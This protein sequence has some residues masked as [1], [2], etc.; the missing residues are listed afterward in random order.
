MTKTAKRITRGLL[1]AL[2][3]VAVVVPGLSGGLIA[4][5]EGASAE[6]GVS[7]PTAAPTF[8]VIDGLDKSKNDDYLKIGDGSME[9]DSKICVD[10]TKTP[11]YTFQASEVGT[12]VT[13]Y[14]LYT[15]DDTSPDLMGRNPKAWKLQGSIDGVN[16]TDIHTVTDDDKLPTVANKA[17]YTYTFENAIPYW[18]Y[19][20]TFTERQGTAGEDY[21]LMQLS[22]IG[23][24]ATA[25]VTEVDSYDA[26]VAAV[27]KGGNIKL[28][29]D[30]TLT[31]ELS[32]YQN[33]VSLDLNGYVISGQ[34]ICV[35]SAAATFSSV[36]M[37]NDSRPTAAHNDEG[38]PAGGVV[39]SEIHMTRRTDD[40]NYANCKAYFYANGGTATGKLYLDTGNALVDHTGDGM[41]VFMGGAY[42]AGTTIN[43][44]FYY[45]DVVSTN[46]ENPF[47]TTNKKVVFKNGDTVY[48]T[49]FAKSGDKVGIM[50]DAPTTAPEAGLM[51]AGW[52][53]YGGFMNNTEKVI[54]ADTTYRAIWMKGVASVA[55]LKA[56]IAAGYGVKLTADIT[57]SED[58]VLADG[59][60]VLVFDLNGHVIGT[61]DRNKYKLRAT[62][63]SKE[64][65]T[66][67][68]IID[69][70]PTA[71]HEGEGLPVGGF[72]N[73]DINM[74]ALWNSKEVKIYANGGTIASAYAGSGGGQIYSTSSTPSVFLGM[75]TSGGITV[76]GGTY[77][78]TTSTQTAIGKL[79][80]EGAIITYMNGETLYAK[81]ETNAKKIEPPA[82]APTKE[83]YRFVGWYIVTDAESGEKDAYDFS[84]PLS[85]GARITLYAEWVDSASPVI[86]GV[87]ADSVY[88]TTQEVTVT[89]DS[90]V[91]VT[92]DGTKVTL[93]GGTFS[94]DM[95]S[96]ANR[97]IVATD[98][99][100]N[101]TTLVVT[102]GH[103]F[104]D[105]TEKVDEDCSTD[106]TL[107]HKDCSDCLGHF[108]EDGVRL[109]S[110]VIPAS[111]SYGAATYV[112]SADARTCTATRVCSRDGAHVETE[113]VDAVASITQQRSC[114]DAE[115]TTYVATFT[116][117]A[118]EGQTK[119]NVET[120]AAAGHVFGDWIYE[121][122]AT[123]KEN[124]VK[125]HAD[126][127]VCH[128]HFD[129]SGNEMTDLIIPAEGLS[130]GAI[131]GIAVGSVAVVGVGAFSIIWF[132]IKKKKF[133]DLIAIFK[134]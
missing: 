18:Y 28:T 74:N 69:S 70:D 22:E 110:L 43:A 52:Y 44:G 76:Q 60:S 25:P 57:F 34:K 66:E 105:W 112:W 85:T 88:C 26:L 134:K 100:G 45:G 38:L 116:N 16:W 113:T 80:G 6:G 125:A 59:G 71:T 32:V 29:G 51:Y 120:Q 3:A 30:I 50:P 37:L 67:I 103:H 93:T 92:V 46:S 1:L 17:G 84:T 91:T 27:T 129:A 89:D 49:Q 53:A 121:V 75:G 108:D 56:A 81:S 8:T 21:N 131:A 97:T 42:G 11:Y 31:E 41:T 65:P 20:I 5:A 13:G 39:K 15:G 35:Y 95:S 111:H 90:P 9:K 58:I 96:G 117:A 133:A 64:T 19:K 106:G 119:A 40:E 73:A 14:T 23:F 115:I 102:Y 123:A 87:D 132:V 48:A 127:S 77:Y 24:T 68:V 2:L 124:G 63:A 98:E 94:L 72:I 122:A 10:I 78:N 36:L 62:G 86:T 128:K 104:G 82:I 126:C 130:G 47:K 101:A 55:E 7:A 109:E 54:T 79:S 33:S 12:I 107:G 118:F 4:L 61:T 83:G 99:K 114:T